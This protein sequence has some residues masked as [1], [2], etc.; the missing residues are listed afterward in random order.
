[1]DA[2]S[3]AVATEDARPVIVA[4]E[5]TKDYRVYK[6]QDRGWLKAALLPFW[7]ERY[8]VRHRALEGIN[9]RISPGEVL[10][11]IGPN[12]S[13]KSTLL[14]ILAGISLPTDGMVDV[15]GHVRCLLA[16]GVTF[17]PRF[18]GRENIIFASVAMGIR[19]K[20]AQRRVDEIIAFSGLGAQIDRPSMFYSSGM[21][22]RLAF[23]VAFQE[24]PEILLLDEALGAGDAAFQ[25]KCQERIAEICASGS[26][27]LMATHSMAALDQLCTRAIMLKSGRLVVDGPPAEVSARYRQALVEQA[28]SRPKALTGAEDA[29]GGES[30]DPRTEGDL[31]R[32]TRVDLV[33]ASMRDALGHPK[34]AF[35]H[36]EPIELHLRLR[37]V[38]EL[39]ILRF[40][41]ELISEDFEIRIA[42]TGSEHL[43]A[44]AGD[45][46]VLP[47]RDATGDHELTVRLPRNPLGSGLYSWTLSI[48]PFDPKIAAEM[49]PSPDY[50]RVVGLCPFR[51]VSFPGRP[52]G[53]LRRVILEPAAVVTFRP[54]EAGIDRDDALDG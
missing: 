15:R 27:V 5:V 31:E 25:I 49:R 3:D 17:R 46:E 4:E 37:G 34:D 30:T 19:A 11:I 54:V 10:G 39:P 42:T 13:G 16:M 44:A 23:A 36:G 8:F 7:R 21:R 47:L 24:A 52:L 2:T 29:R 18:T 1:M 48:R 43:D 32:A 20:V 53:E 51:S 33:A 28:A 50:L 26:T 41:L 40:S 38:G 35:D 6:G 14:R 22:T 9:L 12:G 45:L